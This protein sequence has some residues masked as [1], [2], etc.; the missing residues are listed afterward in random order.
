M[1]H[2]R[3]FAQYRRLAVSAILLPV[4]LLTNVGV[5]SAQPVYSER[6]LIHP[7]F[8]RH[9]MAASQ[10]ALATAAGVAALQ[11]GGN[12]VD[13]AVTI[14]FALAVTLPQAGSLG[15]GGFMLIHDAKS[16]RT[17]AIDH[18]ETAPAATTP[19]LFLNAAGDPDPTLSQDSPLAVGVPGV[20]AG[21]ALALERFGTLSLAAA[22]EPAIRLAEEGFLVSEELSQSLQRAQDRLQRWPATAAIFFR[23]GKPLPAGARLV[24]PDLARSLRDLAAGGPDAFYRGATGDRIVAEINRHGG[25]ITREDLIGYRPVVREPVR[26]RYRDAEIVSMPPP[27]SG[28][29]HLVQILNILEAW[30]LGDLGH[31]SAATIHRMAEAM[32]RAYADR[33]VHLGDPDFVTVP[34]SGLISKGYAELLRGRIDLDRATPAAEIRPGT[35]TDFESAE[36]T[37][38]GVADRFGN[39]VATTTTLNFAYGVGLVADGTGILLNNELDDFAAKPGAA[40]GY[41]LIGGAANA[42]G[43]AKRPLSSM[44]PT[45]VF[46]DGKPFLVTGSPGGA[47]IITTTLQV[48][49]NVIDHGMNVAEACA[50]PR[51]HHQWLP[52]ELRVEEGLSLDTVRL[53][54]GMGHTVVVRDAMGSAQSILITRQGFYGVAD[55]R[56]ASA[57]A[58]GY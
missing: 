11:A 31:N 43:P 35:P 25:R 8:A 56:R 46:R 39:A 27:S 24:Q 9:G 17:V 42:P 50:A 45:L 18:R 23:D 47:R 36:T 6:D 16:G 26:G 7:V 14:G 28:G 21:L 15:G 33:S 51:V 44:A 12:A 32:K 57:A 48:I 4:A 29:V 40:N 38:Y 41:G 20:V 49:L 55:P 58:G 10:E 54:Q 52:D 1:T 34:V 2:V 5:G 22:L 3:H 53:L 13:A 19:T 30:P 37:H